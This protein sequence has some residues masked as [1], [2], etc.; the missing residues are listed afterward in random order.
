M[1]KLR[2][3][4]YFLMAWLVLLASGCARVQPQEASSMEMTTEEANKALIRA[5]SDAEN[6]RDDD[7]LDE[8][9]AEGFTRHSSATP[10]AHVT[11][12]EEFKAYLAANAQSFP[13]YTT[14]IEM[15]VAE[16][17]K[18]AVYAIFKGTMDGPLGELPA[19]GNAAEMP[20]VG[21]FR[22]EEGKIAE[23]WVEWDNV[24]FLS[25]LGLFPPPDAGA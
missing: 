4:S 24:A 21:I 25:E 7:A 23:L 15:M 3:L 20:F 18:V 10:G 5:F 16:D 9:V 22:I 2:S 8:L 19:T 11:S 13:D 1:L 14:T 17:D 12:R 6:A